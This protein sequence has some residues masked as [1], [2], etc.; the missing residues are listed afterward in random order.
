[1]DHNIEVAAHVAEHTRVV[2]IVYSLT[3]AAGNGLW[4]EVRTI[5]DEIVS[6]DEAEARA[7]IMAAIAA[8]A[9]QLFINCQ[10]TN[11]DP[12]EFLSSLALTNQQRLIEALVVIESNG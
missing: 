3:V 10:I 7:V 8:F 5:M 2:G 12:S 1:M 11:N 4:D 6:A 9:G